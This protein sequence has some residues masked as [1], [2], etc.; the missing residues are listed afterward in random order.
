MARGVPGG[1]HA[2]GRPDEQHLPRRA[3]RHAIRRTRDTGPTAPGLAGRA[4]VGVCKPRGL[5][6]VAQDS[7]AAAP[8]SASWQAA[9]RTGR[10]V[11]A[12]TLRA[13]AWATASAAASPRR[14]RS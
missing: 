11:A 13:M 4:D 1:Y 5:A 6:V 12:L 14:V 2:C 9:G 7:R 3:R 8:D 10:G